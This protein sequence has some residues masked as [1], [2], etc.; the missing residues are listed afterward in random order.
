M[1]RRI[2]DVFILDTDSTTYAFRVLDTGYLEHLYYGKKIH[3]CDENLTADAL[4]E[5]HEFAPGNNNIYESGRPGFSFNDMRLEFSANG[6]GDDREPFIEVVHADG[7]RTSDFVFESAETLEGKKMLTQL[8]CAAAK[9]D[10]CS[11]LTV[12]LADKN[13]DLAVELIYHVFPSCDVI[14]RSAKL[15]NR[16]KDSIRI[17]RFMSVQLD[18][19]R[20]DL[21]FTTFNGAWIREM[22]RCDHELSTGRVVSDSVSGTSSSTANPFVMFSEKC[23]DENKGIAYGFNLIYSGNHIEEAEVSE[24]GKLRLLMGINPKG[25]EYILGAGESFEAPEASCN[26]YYQ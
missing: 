23:T 6:K 1:I 19:N 26:P 24:F 22:G 10:E 5:K 8:P 13:Y 18:T 15:I 3:L 14:T 17:L 7:S 11:A 12:T 20:S 4:A 16:G 21:V 2:K 25:F 9:K